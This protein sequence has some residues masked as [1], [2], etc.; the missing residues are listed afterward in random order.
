MEIQLLKIKKATGK[1]I[2]NYA[3]IYETMRM[4]A[5]ADREC[6]WIIHLD[7]R[8]RVIEKEL[9]EMG[10]FSRA[11]ISP[12]LIFKKAIINDS[13]AIICI[14]NHP[15]GSPNP[16]QA[17][18]DVFIQLIQTSDVLEIPLLDFL[19]IS[20]NSYCSFYHEFQTEPIKDYFNQMGIFK[21]EDEKLIFG[22]SVMLLLNGS[23]L[24]DN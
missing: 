19:V 13:K 5:M 17:D 7:Y 21:E 20:E 22:W 12:R 15:T 4:E 10:T 24:L 3:D 6:V 23:T 1:L 16:S 18:Y 11:Y 2:S 8:N 14:H 9:V